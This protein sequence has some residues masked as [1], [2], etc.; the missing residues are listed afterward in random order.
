MVPS[1]TPGAK[2]SAD[3]LAF[4]TFG[5]IQNNEDWVF[6]GTEEEFRK[7]RNEQQRYKY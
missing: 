3:T 5:S 2:V 1:A 4:W 7:F 6:V